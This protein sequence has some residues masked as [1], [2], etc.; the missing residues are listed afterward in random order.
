[1]LWLS[2]V[3][4]PTVDSRRDGHQNQRY[5]GGVASE[6]ERFVDVRCRQRKSREDVIAGFN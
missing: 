4:L 1:M 5:T 3:D 6:L 2:P